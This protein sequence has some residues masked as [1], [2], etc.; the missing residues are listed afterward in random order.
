M[1]DDGINPA[2]KLLQYAEDKEVSDVIIAINK[3][4]LANG[5][6]VASISVACCQLL[7]QIISRSDQVAAE[8]RAGIMTLIDGYAMEATLMSDDPPP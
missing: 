5:A 1:I 6:N 8:M 7:A 2:Q 4:T 3:I